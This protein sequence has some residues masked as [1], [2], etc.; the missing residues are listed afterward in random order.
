PLPQQQT[1]LTRAHPIA[2]AYKWSHSFIRSSY[3]VLVRISPG[4]PQLL[5]RF[6][7]V[8]HPSATRQ[9]KSKLSS[10]TVRLACV[11]H[12]ASVQS[13]PGSNSSI[14]LQCH[15]LNKLK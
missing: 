10:V 7:R 6:P 9:Q 3:S 11:R 14:K 8:T 1:H 13:E 4:Y 12:T 15:Y 5:C 2:N